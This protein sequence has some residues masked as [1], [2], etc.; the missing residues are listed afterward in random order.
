MDISSTQYAIFDQSFNSFGDMVSGN[1]FDAFG[2]D[3]GGF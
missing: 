2:F 3:F 1:D